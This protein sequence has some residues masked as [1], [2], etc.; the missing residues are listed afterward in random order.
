MHSFQILDSE[1]A[2]AGLSQLRDVVQ[3]G[4][5]DSM[6]DLKEFDLANLHEHISA[7]NVNQVR[8][9][10][11]KFLNRST[12]AFDATLDQIA[13]HALSDIL[14]PDLLVQTKLNLSIQLPGDSTS[15]LDLHSD[16]WSGDSPFQ[17]NLWMP[18][19]NCYGTN[20]MFVVPQAESFMAIRELNRNTT[21]NCNELRKFILDKH[22]LNLRFGQAVIFNPGLIHG[23]VVNQTNTTRV[24]VNVRFKGL[25]SPDADRTH[26]SRSAGIY[27]RLFRLSTWTKLALDIDGVNRGNASAPGDS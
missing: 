9:A 3:D 25:F 16:C 27:Y 21:L 15:Q 1:A 23:N 5:R 14:G 26:V 13:G 10:A 18:L 17:V 22:F 12:G 8:L 19:T 20:S 7:S 6:N 11:F 24:S 4:I 2:A